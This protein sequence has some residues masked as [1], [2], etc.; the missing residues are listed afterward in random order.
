MAGKFWRE[1]SRTEC[2]FTFLN[3]KKSRKQYFIFFLYTF[4]MNAGGYLKYLEVHNFKSYKG[5]QRIGPFK[6][7][8]CIIGPNGSGL[9]FFYFL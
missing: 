1:K 5:T 8:S 3:V 2:Q 6:K 9:F 7:F 4:I